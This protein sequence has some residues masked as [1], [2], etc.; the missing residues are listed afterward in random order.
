VKKAAERARVRRIS[1]EQYIAQAL[2]QVLASEVTGHS[3]SKVNAEEFAEKFLADNDEL[4]RLLA[5]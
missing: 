3:Q 1:P 5:G 4:F 2:E